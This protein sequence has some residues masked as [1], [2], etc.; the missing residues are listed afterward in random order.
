MN[1]FRFWWQYLRQKTPWDTQI[2]PPE[3]VTLAENRAAGRA[4]DIGCG[5]GT[6]SLYLAA[7]GWQVIGVDFVPT[8][9]RRAQHKAQSAKL[10]VQ[11]YVAS[12]AKLNFLTGPFDFAIDIGCLHS[13]KPIDQRGYAVQLSRL[14]TVGAV[15]ALY[16]FTPRVINNRKTGLTVES[17]RALFAA[18]FQ[19]EHYTPGKDKGTGPASGW[20][21][22]RRI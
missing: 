20:Y 19:L 4:L 6:T 12:A 5:T 15:Y 14:T 10:P 18:S 7:R 11:F 2:V 13:L 17:I 9:I 8:A 21:Y 1:R 3:I 22:L 16:A